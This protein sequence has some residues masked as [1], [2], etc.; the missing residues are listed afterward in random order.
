V[1]VIVIVTMMIM[2]DGTKNWLLMRMWMSFLELMQ[3]T[4]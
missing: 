2:I 3:G 4:S 1:I